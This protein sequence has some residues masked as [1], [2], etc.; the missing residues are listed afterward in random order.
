MD[1]VPAGMGDDRVAPV[2]GRLGGEGPHPRPEVADLGDVVLDPAPELPAAAI[3][4]EVDRVPVDP[5]E[6]AGVGEDGT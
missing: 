2:E 3:A 6:P 1:D 5:D 4:E